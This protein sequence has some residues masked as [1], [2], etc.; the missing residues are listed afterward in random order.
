[1]T[2]IR[3]TSTIQRHVSAPDLEVD[4]NTVDE[5]LDRYFDRY[6]DVRSYV[7]DNQGAV[8]HHMLVLADGISI[9]DRL[10]LSDSVGSDTELFIFQALSGG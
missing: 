4:A 1:M 6:P 7:L 8:R 9:T 5:A 3:F 2:T 10:R